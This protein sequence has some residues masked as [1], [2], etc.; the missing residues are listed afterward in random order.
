MGIPDDERREPNK[1]GRREED[2]RWLKVQEQIMNLVTAERTDQQELTSIK[3]D[4][5]RLSDH[6]EDIDDCLRGVAGSDSL[7][8]RVALLERESTANGVLLRQIKKQIEELRVS[9]ADLKIANAISRGTEDNKR[10]RMAQWLGFWGPIIITSIGL[11][12][13]LAKVI[14][15]HIEKTRVFDDTYR[16]DERLRRQIEADKKSQ[17]GKEAAKRLRELEEAQARNR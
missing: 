1:A 4:V 13:P 14:V 10:S 16:P 11:S 9:L 12:V 2:N 15:E 7:S 5:S 6:V 3:A 8:N 17:R